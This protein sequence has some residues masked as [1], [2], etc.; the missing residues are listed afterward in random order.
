MQL[1]PNRNE[2]LSPE[3]HG[4]SEAAAAQPRVWKLYFTYLAYFTFTARVCIFLFYDL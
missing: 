1:R 2:D 4:G 3:V